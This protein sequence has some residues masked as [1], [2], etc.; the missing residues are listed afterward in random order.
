MGQGSKCIAA[1]LGEEAEQYL[2]EVKGQIL[3][4][5]EPRAEMALGVGY[6][7]APVGADHM[8]NIHNRVLVRR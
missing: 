4:M 8:M 3:P 2:V 1:T 7:T 6:A 5:H